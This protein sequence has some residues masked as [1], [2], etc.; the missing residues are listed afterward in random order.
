MQTRKNRSFPPVKEL[1]SEFVDFQPSA[2]NSKHI[3]VIRI[4]NEKCEDGDFA[5]VSQGS[6]EPAYRAPRK[7]G[8][9]RPGTFF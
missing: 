1:V 4:K 2:S 7:Y 8:C 6:E 3:D 9:G 5:G